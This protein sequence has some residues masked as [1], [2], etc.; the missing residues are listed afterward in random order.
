M[1]I[2]TA[3]PGAEGVGDGVGLVGVADVDEEPQPID[4]LISSAIKVNDER[5][6]TA[7]TKVGPSALARIAPV[8][9]ESR[10]AMCARPPH[11]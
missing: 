5:I 4:R 7:P 3:V 8:A 10:A 6:H 9:D 2:E 11:T 1:T